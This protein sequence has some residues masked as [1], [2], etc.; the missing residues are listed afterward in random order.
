MSRPCYAIL[1]GRGVLSVRGEDSAIFLQGLV[2]NDVTRATAER[3]V[4]AALLTAQGKF[5]HDLFVLATDQALLLDCEYDRRDDL[6]RRLTLYK[7][8]S[9]AELTDVS[10]R[11]LVA[12]LFGDN[13]SAILGLNAEPGRARPLAGGVVC[14]DPRLSDLGARAILPRTTAEASLAALGFAPAGIDAYD[15]HRL[16]LGVPDGSRDMKAGSDFLLECNGDA[17]NAIDWN[18]GCY[19]GQEITARSRYRGTVRKRLVP[20][21]IKGPLPLPGAPVTVSGDAGGT[22]AGEMRTA[23][24]GR[25]IALLRLDCLNRPLAAGQAELR[26]TRPDWLPV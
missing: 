9:R 13:L 1:V 12:A 18:K 25:G 8:R 21:A 4:Y 16:A 26:A 2:S 24:D 22:V 20:V 6:I 19:V 3:A 5:L 17:L 10:D 7:L 23:Q 15:R 11:Y 14:I